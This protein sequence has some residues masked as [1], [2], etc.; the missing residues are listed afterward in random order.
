[1]V[2]ESGL[3]T[4]ENDVPGVASENLR[5]AEE[6]AASKS[7]EQ[8]GD[9]LEN[10]AKSEEGAE[11]LYTGVGRTDEKKAKGKGFF[12]RKGPM[13]L[14]L[15]LIV[16]GGGLMMGSQSL[17]P[18]AIEEMIIEKFNSIGISTTIASDT[19][20]DTQ[21]NQGV[22]SGNN[23]KNLFAFSSY[24]VESF[25][26]QGLY[27]VNGEG[28]TAI[29]YLKDGVYIPVVG[30][31]L[32]NGNTDDLVE[33]I[34]KAGNVSNVGTPV[35]TKTALADPIF[36][37]PYTTASKTWRG[38][39]SGWFDEIMK[40]VTETKLSINRNRWARYVAGSIEDM[41]EE[42]N[43]AAASA[44]KSRTSDLVVESSFEVEGNASNYEVGGIYSGSHTNGEATIIISKTPIKRV[45]DKG[46]EYI[47]GYQIKTS[48]ADG[49]VNGVTESS[50]AKILNS[51]AVK[52]AGMV[53][54]AANAGCA[55]VEGIMSIY[56]VVSAYQG[57][58]F[59]NL[60][61]G[62][63]E[64][65]D[66]VKAGA[67]DGSPIH[68]YSNNLT[69]KAETVSIK[70]DGN[71]S[72]SSMGGTVSTVVASKTAMES[73]GMAWLFS[74]NN[75][76][77]PADTSVQNVNLE[78]IMSN[79]S[80]LTKN[81]DLTA[82]TFEACGYI[83]IATA[84]FDLVTTALSFIPIFGGAIKFANLT[85]K[86]VAKAA[87][88]AA[89]SIAFY[90]MIPVIA[91]KVANSIIKDAA[92]EWFGEDLGNAIISGAGKY[93][94]GNGTSGGQGPGSKDKV[95]AY[96]KERDVVIADEARYQRAM[97]SPFDVNS[98][99]TFLG[100]LMYSLMPLAYSGSG[101]MSAVR[102]MSSLTNSSIVAL[103]PTASAI[104]KNSMLNSEGKCALADNLGVVSD[105]FCNAYIITD[106]STI[107]SSPIAVA[108]IVRRI[109]DNEIAAKNNYVGV[110]N[111][112]FNK[113]GSIK[114][115][116]NLAKYITYCGQ[117]TSQYGV[118]DAAIAERISGGGGSL[119]NY[120]PVLSNLSSINSAIKDVENM[121]WTTGQACVASDDNKIWEENKWYQRYAENERL[122]ENTNPGYKSPVTAY[123]KDYYKKNPVDN[124][125]EGQ[126][127]RFS[128]MSKEKVEDTLA[129]IGY[130]QFL[131]QYDASERYA[132]G[133][134]IVEEKHD[135]RFDNENQ[136][137]E[138]IYITL[139]NDIEFADVRNRNFVV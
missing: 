22:Q 63:L 134:P 93:L 66:K 55:I 139:L 10:V 87:I 6:N 9:S 86:V 85:F 115:N 89:V 47:W 62:F 129:L 125:F 73:Q 110:S 95:L 8:S 24:Q 121:Q 1:M 111:D 133:A 77:N 90:T 72:E 117:R 83:R 79:I 137:A 128:G 14:I 135:L 42:F 126:I 108:D 37:E 61:S 65:V 91:K 68:N 74:Q 49:A 21:L 112:N 116:S 101:I 52:A 17:M 82:K 18:M 7:P 132:F 60:I 35:S 76:I 56:T 103:S 107:Y 127:A 20:L 44:V 100:S 43:K 75:K 120:I 119:L 31:K 104:D 102:K 46:E 19:W 41:T 53:A 69:T 16:G 123:L 30:S 32:L 105:A 15:G 29:L 71:A 28:V 97:R 59:L 98:Q 109:G 136:V 26:K 45:N 25:K 106:T 94:G 70:S 27:V 113:D 96:L 54:D 2:E 12:K 3:N 92:T 13:G 88:K 99:Y 138:N 33:K 4:L 34:K 23:D 80:S 39:A 67:D 64:S 78:T 122:L 51:K 38:G 131:A 36:K 114:E 81:V 40:N 50:L 57:L 58:Q 5:R 11:G 84:T 130:Y 48:N 118:R 124:S